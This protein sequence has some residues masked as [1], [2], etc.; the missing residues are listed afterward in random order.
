[1]VITALIAG[2]AKASLAG[3]DLLTTTVDSLFVNTYNA[4]RFAGD[5]EFS[6]S[7]QESLDEIN[8]NYAGLM[9]STGATTRSADIYR[10]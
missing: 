2:S 5:D 6:T 10:P 9:H 7:M 8:D 3:Y 1:M 4:Q